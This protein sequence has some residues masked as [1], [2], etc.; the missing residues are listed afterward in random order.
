MTQPWA[1]L[2]AALINIHTG[3]VV[4]RA[5][6]QH[7]MNAFQVHRYPD[8]FA[9]DQQWKS[10]IKKVGTQQ[11]NRN[12]AFHKSRPTV[13]YTHIEHDCWSRN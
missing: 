2:C 7:H 3:E 6:G 8:S 9:L 11:S 10:T 12:Q 4:R 1:E 13:R 5:F